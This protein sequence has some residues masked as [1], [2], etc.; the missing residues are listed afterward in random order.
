LNS[1]RRVIEIGSTAVKNLLRAREGAALGK[2]RRCMDKREYGVVVPVMPAGSRAGRAEGPAGPG[3]EGW[4]VAQF[5]MGLLLLGGDELLRYLRATQNEIG[6][7][8]EIPTTLVPGKETGRDLVAYLALGAMARGQKRL[9]QGLRRGVRYS[10]AA[11]ELAFG[12]MDLLT[13]NPLTRPVREPIDRW[14]DGLMQEGERVVRERQRAA[15]S[16]RLL[17]TRTL[18]VMARDVVAGVAES[19]AV[20]ETI[21]QVVGGQGVELAGTMMDSA[22]QVS[23]RADSR[24]EGVVRRLLRRR[25]RRELPL[26]PL[27]GK[28]QTMYLSWDEPEEGEGDGRQTGTP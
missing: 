1:S 15:Q 14:L 6:A 17:A 21:Q 24:V 26:S 3:S 28:P 4:L 11:A 25:P 20:T 2:A 5:L 9:A 16:A 8:P 19:P 27:V 23:A 22:R 13:N 7:A 18:G 12:A 10:T